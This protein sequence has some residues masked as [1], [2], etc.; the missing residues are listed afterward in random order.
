MKPLGSRMKQKSKSDLC[1][2]IEILR[3]ISLALYKELEKTPQ[4]VSSKQAMDDFIK[5]VTEKV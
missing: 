2:E 4:T 1:N 5:Y 3:G